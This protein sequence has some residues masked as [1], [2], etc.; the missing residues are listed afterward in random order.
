MQ[1]VAWQQSGYSG[2]CP[3][4]LVATIGDVGIL[5]GVMNTPEKIRELARKLGYSL[6]RLERE[7]GL[8]QGRLTKVLDSGYLRSEE[9]EALG[10]VLGASV[11]ELA[12]LGQE[13][14][15]ERAFLDRL[16]QEHG[17]RAVIRWVLEGAA[18]S[19]QV[20]PVKLPPQPPRKTDGG[21]G[22]GPSPRKS[23]A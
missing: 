7:A 20:T 14:D 2:V 13:P 21:S 5:S 23:T 19:P 11:P 4:S 10:K 22:D 6:R 8:P 18:A 16:V 1:G 12:G 15:P 9:L 3:M 17:L